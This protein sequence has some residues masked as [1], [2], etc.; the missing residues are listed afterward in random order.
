MS[1]L[2]TTDKLIKENPELVQ[3]VVDRLSISFY[4]SL[5]DLAF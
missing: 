5:V 3:A 2:F 4:K 1:V